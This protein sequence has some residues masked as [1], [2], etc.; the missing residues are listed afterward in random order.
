MFA[1]ASVMQALNRFFLHPDKPLIL[2]LGRPD[3]RKNISGLVRAY[4][5]DLD[6]QAMANLAVFAGI[7]KDI[8]SMEGNEQE[9]LTDM[10]LRLDR[11]DPRWTLLL[12]HGTMS[13]I[14]DGIST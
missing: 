11:Y 13:S 3:K 5:E 2:A 14:S 12:G 8:G 10:L 4:G 9:V 6:L 7:R 1:R